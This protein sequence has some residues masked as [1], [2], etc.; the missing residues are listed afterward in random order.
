MPQIFSAL[1]TAHDKLTIG[2][3]NFGM[4]YGTAP[5]SGQVLAEEAA[6]IVVSAL[7]KGIDRFDTAIGYGTA[8]DVVGKALAKA[9]VSDA[10]VVTKILPLSG[11]MLDEAGATGIVEQVHQ[12]RDRLGVQQLDAVLVH[13]TADLIEPQGLQLWDVLRRVRDKG[14]VR[15][16]GVSVYDAS[17]IDA[18]LKRFDPDVMQLP[19]SIADQRLI[20]SGHLQKL[21]E[22]GVE[23][24]ARSVFLQGILLDGLDAVDAIFDR[25]S[26]EIAALNVVAQRRGV[27][28]LALCLSFVAQLPQVSQVVVGVNSTDQ[29]DAI[30]AAAARSI[31]TNASETDA[32]AWKDE[33]LL[34]P[35]HWPHLKSAV[36][37]EV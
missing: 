13:R 31:E 24:H 15:K 16:V 17:D 2:T 34:N 37:S 1:K 35:S 10:K 14:L 26:T 19:I 25:A 18:I 12:A 7:E 5:G 21:A 27:S 33:Q 11:K 22:R 9:K 23:V 3:V 4:P 28:R 36:L 20:R 29:F 8:E 30:V 32:C 6:A